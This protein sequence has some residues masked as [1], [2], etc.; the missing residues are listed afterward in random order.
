MKIL[1]D[2]HAFLWFVLN[3]SSL[4]GRAHALISDPANEILLS[5]VTYWEV[6]IKIRLG[7]FGLPGPFLPFM[8]R[9]IEQNSFVILPIELTH[10]EVVST[11]P[12]HHRD[13]F[14]RMLVAQAMVERVPILS[15]DLAL[16]AYPAARIW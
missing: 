2:T 13:P 7:K 3:D 10:A 12:F 15:A 11:L 9:Q 6:A 1:L 4:P 14:D 16:D 5:P 8:T